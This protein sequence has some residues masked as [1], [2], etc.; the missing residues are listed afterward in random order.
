MRYYFQIPRTHDLCL[1]CQTYEKRLYPSAHFVCNTTSVDTAADSLAGLERMNPFE[2]MMSRRY[3]KT[4]R[5]QQFMEL[6]RYISGVNQVHRNTN[7]V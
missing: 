6:F 3:Q 5:T 4:P 1:L 2:V 7:N